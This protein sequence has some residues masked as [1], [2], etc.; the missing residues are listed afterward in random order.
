M[1]Y[2]QSNLSAGTAFVRFMFGTVMTTYGTIRLLREPKSRSG[3]MLVL[4][5]SMKAAEGVTKFCPKKAIGTVMENLASENAKQTQSGGTATNS[6]T[7]SGANGNIMQ[8]VGS[9]AQKITSGNSSSTSSPQNNGQNQNSTAPSQSIGNIAQTIAPQM[10][11]I[12]KEVA[13]LTGSQT[14]S[15]T[16]QSSRASGSTAPKTDANVNA[17]KKEAST[18]SSNMNATSGSNTQ[19]TKGNNAPSSDTKQQASKA[20]NSNINPS[21]IDAMSKSSTQSKTTPNILQ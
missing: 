17:N 12:V 8:M 15:E 3:K 9:I 1:A 19:T 4:F 5:G 20:N 21:A 6:T 2:N 16:K 14:S 18:N 7:Q 10:S 13:G 11:Q